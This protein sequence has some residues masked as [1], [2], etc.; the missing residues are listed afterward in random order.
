VDVNKSGIKEDNVSDDRVLKAAF[1]TKDKLRVN[2][3]F[4]QTRY[5]VVYEISATDARQCATI[6]YRAD[7][8]SAAGCL[9]G[10]GRKGPGGG[11]G[12]GGGKK[13]EEEIN[14]HEILAKVAGL[15]GISVLFV[16]KPLNAFSALA[17][18]DTRIFTVKVDDQKEIADVIARLQEMLI[19]EPPRWLSHAMTGERAEVEA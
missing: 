14:E 16:D 8:P 12:C 13:K 4:E 9:E 1:A 19:G 10:P 2:A 6:T 18:N 5:I 15:A 11:C 7:S 3:G 17:L